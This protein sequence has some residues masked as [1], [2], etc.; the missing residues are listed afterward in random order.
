MNKIYV[1]DNKSIDDPT[2][3]LIP[4]KHGHILD[5]NGKTEEM[6]G[7]RM[8]VPFLD[9]S[10]KTLFQMADFMDDMDE[11]FTHPDVTIIIKEAN[12]DHNIPAKIGIFA[13]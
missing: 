1:L 5:K 10:A 3:D 12:K 4:E 11:T 6:S 7:V 8:T 2:F 9:I 13:I